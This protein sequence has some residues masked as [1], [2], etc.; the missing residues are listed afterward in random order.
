MPEHWPFQCRS[1][2]LFADFT[3]KALAD[4]GRGHSNATVIIGSHGSSFCLSCVVFG[5]R[6]LSAFG[7][8][9]CLLAR[10]AALHSLQ[11][12]H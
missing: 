8:V 9:C 3:S 11:G 10:L 6:R 5:E 12:A 7:L 4:A 1:C 2:I